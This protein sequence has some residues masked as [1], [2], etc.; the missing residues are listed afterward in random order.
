MLEVD[1]GVTRPQL[2]PQ[3][4]ARDDLARVVEKPCEN[5]KW[6]LLEGNADAILA[7]L[8]SAQV[9][10]EGGSNQRRRAGV[11]VRH[12]A[13]QSPRPRRPADRYRWANVM[14]ARNKRKDQ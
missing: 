10:I 14:A 2:A 9:D 4:L 1:Q 11:C 7:Q 12:R 13:L 8:A 5:S 6:L 3:R